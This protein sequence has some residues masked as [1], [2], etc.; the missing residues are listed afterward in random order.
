M[1]G[2]PTPGYAFDVLQPTAPPMHHCAHF[3]AK[4]LLS[5]VPLLLALVLSSNLA[6][7]QIPLSG[8]IFDG[9]GGPLL[10][11]SV[12]HAGAISVP[13]GQTLTVQAG[14]IVKFNGAGSSLAVSGTL[15]VNGTSGNPAIFTSIE[16]DAAGGDTNANGA[17]APAKGDWRGLTFTATDTST[18]DWCEVRYGGSS[19]VPLVSANNADISLAHCTLRDGLADALDLNGNSFP[20]VSDCTFTDCAIAVDSV[21]IDAVPG[22]TNNSASGN[23]GNYIRI[24]G[25]ILNASAT[26][27]TAN[28]LGG[29]LVCATSID[30]PAG[31]TLT[32]QAGVIFKHSVATASWNVNAGTLDVNGTSA[33]PVIFTS[34]ADDS[35]GGDTNGD[36]PSSGSAGDWREV[37]FTNSDTST[38][39]WCEL[40]YGGLVSPFL[41][42][43]GSEMLLRDCTVR[44]ALGDGMSLN[45]QSFPSVRNCRFL[46]NGGR[47]V[48]AVPLR[49]VPGFAF[50]TASGNAAGDYMR[51]ASA[52][53]N[54]V[55]EIEDHSVL[56]GALV[57]A[58]STSIGDGGHL[59]LGP[60]VVLKMTGA[61]IILGHGNAQLTLAGTAARPVVVTAFADDTVGGDTNADGA[62]T[63]P[64]KGSWTNLS[65]SQGSATLTHALF[66]YG[67]APGGTPSPTIFSNFVTGVAMESVRVEHG[68]GTGFLLRS[69][70]KAD[71]LC[72]FDNAQGFELTSGSYDLTRCTAV[73]NGTGINT[74]AGFMG[75]VVSSIA[76]GN[77][78]NFGGTF[79]ALFYSNGSTSQAGVNGN[80]DTDPLFV[81]QANGDLVL[82][83]FS[84]SVD[85]GDPLGAVDPDC[86][87]ADQGAYPFDAGGPFTYCTGK[88]NTEGCEP[89]VDYTG[90]ASTTSPEPFLLT[91]NDILNN[92]PGLFFYGTNGPFAV[93]FEGGTLCVLPPL[94]RTEVTFSGGSPPPND[95][96]GTQTYDF[97]ER[98]QS[99]GDPFLVPGATVNG[100]FWTRDPLAA[101]GTGLTNGVQFP[102]CP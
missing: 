47:A 68:L 81:D 57:M 86:T 88:T 48:V 58:T 18:L 67:G 49:A 80:I 33:A 56:N 70:Q 72:A 27:S 95:C 35:A 26:I 22:F 23:A 2:A 60:G 63:L 51:V 6:Q 54:T 7:A 42:L 13:A 78:I 31:V 41:F 11:G 77:G 69:A 3:A 74:S 94:R 50:N 10:S 59:T 101:Q 44:D 21:D 64:A 24:T 66:R 16:D 8:S 53:I 40:R 100:Q 73:A 93:P 17:V 96:S 55:V 39:Q 82:T 87:P 15:D 14:A 46:D 84:P 71:R 43:N 62:A 102:I 91:A 89:F 12:Y 90:Q 34:F 92:K 98:I 37:T 9:S 52:S 4:R 99:G 32:L 36:G 5:S 65:I 25:G 97:N 29:A 38:L 30:V 79:P 28:V 83:M 76:W 20:T 61:G 1:A 75:R 85:M 45:S 19:N